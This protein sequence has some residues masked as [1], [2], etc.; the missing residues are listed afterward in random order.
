M[1]R[2]S[3]E[4]S[5]E[6]ISFIV[7]NYHKMTKRA[8]AK[9]LG[10]GES[11]IK[12]KARKLGIVGKTTKP[13]SKADE[14]YLKNNYLDKSHKEMGKILNRSMDS[15][16]VKCSRMGLNKDDLGFTEDE[17]QYLE[18]NYNKL[19]VKAIAKNLDKKVSTIRNKAFQMDYTKDQYIY[20]SMFFQN[21]NT[22][23]KA[24]WLGFIYADGCVQYAGNKQPRLTI[25]LMASDYKHLEKFIH[26]INGEQTVKIRNHGEACAIAV[27]SKDMGNDLI[28][29]GVVPRKTYERIRMPSMDKSLVRHFIRGFVDGDGHIGYGDYLNKRVDKYYRK[30][31]FSLTSNY[32]DILK[33]IQ[34][35]FARNSIETTIYKSR[36]VFELKTSARLDVKNILKLLYEDSTIYL[37]RKYKTSQIM[38]EELAP[39]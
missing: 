14:E 16:K 28:K 26:S 24:Y 2:K 32:T 35:Y 17:L 18:D 13:Y 29:L 6:D 19:D 10:R 20:N 8:I 5:D 9:K 11:A 33:D 39:Y 7:E 15:V 3:V 37:D 12:E 1:S 23:E 34:L 22:E 4:Y 30:Y 27:H 25:G 36:D 38:L 31:R 21:I